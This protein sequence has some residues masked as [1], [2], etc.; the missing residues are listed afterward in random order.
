MEKNPDQC[1]FLADYRDNLNN[2]DFNK[3]I[4]GITQFC[5]DYCYE[6]NIK[7]EPIAV[8]IVYEAPNNLC[9]ERKSLIDFFQMHGID[10]KELDY[11]IR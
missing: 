9:S 5:N 4:K 10:C 6:N 11:P 8:L 2:I 1:T 3:M 7:E